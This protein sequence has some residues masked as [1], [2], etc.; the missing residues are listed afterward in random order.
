MLKEENEYR[1]QY[2]LLSA[3]GM[4]WEIYPDFTGRWNID[5]IIFIKNVDELVKKRQ[6]IKALELFRKHKETPIAQL[7]NLMSPIC[8]YFYMKGLSIED[9]HT[10]EKYN[11][12]QDLINEELQ[13]CFNVIGEIKKLLHEDKN[14]TEGRN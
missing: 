6:A 11:E 7:R 13:R 9:C 1:K 10:E 4:M 8:N 5:K 3:S 12:I 14:W 2:D